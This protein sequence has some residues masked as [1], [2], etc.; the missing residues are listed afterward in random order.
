MHVLIIDDHHLF[1]RALRDE[2][3]RLQ[4]D[5]IVHHAASLSAALALLSNQTPYDI[6]FV[7]L[8]LPDASGMSAVNAVIGAAG[9]AK[10]AVVSGFGESHL[11]REIYR[12]GAAGYIPKGF[13]IGPLQLA[14][15]RLLSGGFSFP[16]EL[17]ES[18]AQSPKVRDLTKRES[19]V[20]DELAQGL[21]TKLIAR[22]LGLAPTTIDKHIDQIR[23][24]AGVATR[25]QLVA[26]I[27]EVRASMNAP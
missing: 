8:K 6:V 27:R 13:E 15:A 11:V 22:R 25:M 19:Q 20:L 24:K 7:D 12:A 2:I 10:V 4:P 1:A 21:S 16:A 14:L 18:Q 17:L 9:S 3:C 5:P 23:A 26:K